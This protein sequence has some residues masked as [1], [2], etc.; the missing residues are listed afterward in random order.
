[1]KIHLLATALL[2]AVASP[3]VVSANEPEDFAVCPDDQIPC[4]ISSDPD[5]RQERDRSSSACK[6]TW[7][8]GCCTRDCWPDGKGGRICVIAP[9]SEDYF[10]LFGLVDNYAGNEDSE[11]IDSKDVATENLADSEDSEEFDSD[12]EDSEDM[13]FNNYSGWECDVNGRGNR[14]RSNQEL[15]NC[16]E[17]EFFNC[18][19]DKHDRRIR[20]SVNCARQ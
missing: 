12:S 7:S 3:G 18:K 11:D 14:I 13:I 16:C 4:D 20:S 1:M 9:P 2:A 19:D 15:A 8:Q 6:T 17:N 5:C 10:G